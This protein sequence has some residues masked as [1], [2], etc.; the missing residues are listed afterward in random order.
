[1]RNLKLCLLS[2]GDLKPGKQSSNSD[3]LPKPRHSLSV[4]D[5]KPGQDS[6]ILDRDS[7]SDKDGNSQKPQPQLVNSTFVSRTN[8]HID[9]ISRSLEPKITL[10][11]LSI[12]LLDE[13]RKKTNPHF[14]SPN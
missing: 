11:D 14:T 3:S 1:M 7:H 9:A 13:F 2:K 12:N 8:P 6:G 10:E 4:E 5:R